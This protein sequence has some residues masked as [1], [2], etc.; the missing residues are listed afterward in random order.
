MRSSKDDGTPEVVVDHVVNG[1]AP[2]F[3]TELDVVTSGLPG[4]VVDEMPVR[5]HAITR[6][7]SGRADLREAAYADGRKT[8]VI[9]SRLPYSIRWKRA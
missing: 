8:R 7:R 4:I 6:H 3:V 1:C 2:E 5:V 9:A